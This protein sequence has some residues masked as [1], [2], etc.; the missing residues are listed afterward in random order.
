[1]SAQQRRPINTAF[2]VAALLASGC[3]DSSLSSTEVVRP[4]LVAVDPQNFLSGRSCTDTSGSLRS[5]V[6]TFFDVTPAGGAPQIAAEPTAMGGGGGS[7]GVVS[8][9]GAHNAGAGQAG[10][11]AQA[12]SGQAGT[13]TRE[14]TSEA[15]LPLDAKALKSSPPVGCNRIVVTS[16]VTL[17]NLYAVEIDGYDYAPADLQPDGE[18]GTRQMRDASGQLVTPRWKARC[19]DRPV[20]AVNRA[21]QY[22]RFC[23]PLVELTGKP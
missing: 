23:S 21:T 12:G 7:G 4:T 22:I 15:P 10:A 13:A 1:M 3:F 16:N 17:G 20:E 6:A 5:Y 8:A 11:T 19:S 2:L 9:A 18:P 14:P